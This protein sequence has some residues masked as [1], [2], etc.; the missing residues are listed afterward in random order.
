M[1]PGIY[2]NVF[3]VKV[4]DEAVQVM[5]ASRASF[6][7]LRSLRQ[8]LA[9]AGKNAWVYAD[10]DTV[11]GYG[12]DA[13]CLESRGFRKALL[14]LTEVPRLATRMVIEGLVSVLRREGYEILPRKG[15]QQAYHPEK[16]TWVVRGRV[17]VHRGYDLRALFWKDIHTDQLAFGLIADIFWVLRDDKNSRSV[18]ARSGNN[19]GTT[20]LLPLARFRGNTYLVIPSSIPKWLVSDF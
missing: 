16:F 17:R 12:L 5:T 9:E 7:D 15:R 3:P 11:Y 2:L 13:A 20:S 8:R 1:D 4:P 19:T 18:C 14:R 6:Q 10:G